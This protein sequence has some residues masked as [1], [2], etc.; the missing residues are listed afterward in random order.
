[1][2]SGTPKVGVL[3]YFVAENCLKMK[4]I[5][6]PGAV[7]GTPLRPTNGDIDSNVSYNVIISEPL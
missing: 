4:E 2:T 1:M 5:G 3:T 6:L 7:P